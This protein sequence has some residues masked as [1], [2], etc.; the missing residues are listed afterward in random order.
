MNTVNIIQFNDNIF[1]S[2]M[3]DFVSNKIESSSLI[4][5]KL[6]NNIHKLDFHLK[7]ENNHEFTL[8]VTCLL[9]GKPVHI[10]EQGKDFYILAN[11]LIDKLEKVIR[12]NKDKI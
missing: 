3:R 8:S 10:E 7:K 12:R 11:Q 4:Q 6:M 5:S 2:P 1:S 9:D